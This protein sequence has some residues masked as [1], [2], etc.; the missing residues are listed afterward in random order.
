M[1]EPPHSATMPSTPLQH[2]GLH[3]AGAVVDVERRLLPGGIDIRHSRHRACFPRSWLDRRRALRDPPARG[4]AFSRAADACSA[5]CPA[6]VDRP[7][8]VWQR[9]IPDRRAGCIEAE[10][11]RVREGTMKDGLRVFDA[12]THVEPTAEVSTSM[13]I[14]AFGRASPI[15]RRTASRSG[16]AI[17][18]ARRASTSIATARFPSPHPRRGGA[19][20]DP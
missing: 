16:P 14:R 20:R 10:T 3:D 7:V 12:D 8:Q 5:A 1:H 6:T 11:T 2:R 9:A 13:S 4:R 18:A 17:R 15:W 19:A